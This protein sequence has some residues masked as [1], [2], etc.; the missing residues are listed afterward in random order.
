LKTSGA[1]ACSEAGFSKDGLAT[2][3]F[4]A[5]PFEVALLEAGVWAASV[6]PNKPK[7]RLMLVKSALM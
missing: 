1:L 5:V 6:E 7:Q 4:D 3:V 2:P